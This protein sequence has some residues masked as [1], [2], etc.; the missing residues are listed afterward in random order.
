MFRKSFSFFRFISKRSII[1]ETKLGLI[2]YGTKN[3]IY[4]V[5]STDH[6][7]TFVNRIQSSTPALSNTSLISPTQGLSSV[8]LTAIFPSSKDSLIMG[9]ERQKKYRLRQH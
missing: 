8:H 9:K 5:S 7:K 2:I 4:I 1:T 3:I 6:L